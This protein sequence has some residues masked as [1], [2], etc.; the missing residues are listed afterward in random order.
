MITPPGQVTRVAVR[1]APTDLSTKTK[2]KDLYFPFDPTGTSGN[3]R[4]GFVHHCHMTEH[5]DNEMMRPNLVTLNPD[6]P[7]PASR[8]LKKGVDY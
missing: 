4:Y 1:Y 8:L 3:D 6:A 5:E 7:T 2:A